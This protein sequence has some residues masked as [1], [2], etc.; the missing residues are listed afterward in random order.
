MSTTADVRERGRDVVVIDA[1]TGS[2]LR[3]TVLDCAGC[4]EPH[5]Y[6][7]SPGGRRGAFITH[8]QLDELYFVPINPRK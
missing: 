4:V 8:A 2:E 3:A 6:V 7:A 5:A 1:R